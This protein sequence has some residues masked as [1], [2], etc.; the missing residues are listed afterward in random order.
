[1]HKQIGV[2][3]ARYGDNK[4][5]L[6]YR[7][8]PVVKAA[9]S[10]GQRE[11]METVGLVV[12]FMKEFGCPQ[13][14][15][16]VDGVGGGVV[17]RLLELGYNNVFGIHNNGTPHD[18]EQYRNIRAEAAWGLRERFEES[19]I[20]LLPVARQFPQYAAQAA[21]I[22]WKVTSSGIQLETKEEMMK[23][24]VPSPDYFDSLSLA[25]LK[26]PVSKLITKTEAEAPLTAGFQTK[27]F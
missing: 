15:V 24:K 17:D 20:S 27:V 5:V 3:V 25:F 16:D 14:M 13:T 12:K 18:K 21:S 4:T 7:E 2:D 9:I 22:K 8:G 10:Y 11:T 23:R 26:K 19:N 1:N 6:T